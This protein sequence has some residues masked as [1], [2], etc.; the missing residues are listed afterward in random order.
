MN[1]LTIIGNLTRD[2]ETRTASNGK[3]V[4]TYTANDGT[5]RANMEM[6]ATDV[7]FLS[8]RENAAPAASNGYVPVTDEDLPF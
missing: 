8:P 7:E 6:T 3:N 2:P 5:T 1:K 4:C